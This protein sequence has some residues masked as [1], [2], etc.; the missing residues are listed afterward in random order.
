M[1]GD[2]D[3]LHDRAA[4]RLPTYGPRVESLGSW[5]R[6]VALAKIPTSFAV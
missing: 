6:Y 1:A 2:R 4:G 5:V 3:A